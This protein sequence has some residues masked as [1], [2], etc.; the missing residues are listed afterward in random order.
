MMWETTPLII[1]SC[2]IMVSM[3][4]ITSSRSE[5]NS[6]ACSSCKL[7]ANQCHAAADHIEG[8]KL[9]RVG[10]GA[11]YRDLRAS[12][13]CKAH[14]HFLWRSWNLLHSQSARV[15]EPYS[16]SQAQSGQG[17]DGLTGLGDDQHQGMLVNQRL[18]IA[19]LGG[20]GHSN[21]DPQDRLHQ[22]PRYH[23]GMHGS[24]TGHDVDLIAV[25]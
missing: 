11:G 5:R 23:T 14:N 4:G 2:A 20:N 25:V 8:G 6:I 19:E 16:S 1:F 9:Y 17:V 12:H 21:R 24:S 22:R 13:G 15:L 10:L 3:A 18:L 7:A